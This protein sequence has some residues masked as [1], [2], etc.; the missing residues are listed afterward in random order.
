MNRLHI[1]LVC[2]SL[3]FSSLAQQTADSTQ[4]NTGVKDAP[5]IKSKKTKTRAIN[6]PHLY[7]GFSAG[8]GQFGLA[9][10]NQDMKLSNN[11][12]FTGGAFF[13]LRILKWL[14]A[15]IGCNY[16]MVSGSAKI[17]N[18]TASINAKDDEGDS[19]V[20]IIEAPNVKEEMEAELLEIPLSAKF[21]W[22]P[23]KWNL[24][25]KPG[26]AYSMALSSGYSQK[27]QVAISGHYPTE[28]ITFENLPQ[29]GY[30][31]MSHF[32][33]KGEL[34]IKNSI[35]PFIGAG[36]VFPAKTG[37][38]FIEGKYYPGTIDFSNGAGNGTLFEGTMDNQNIQD[39]NFESITEE[40]SK[41]GLGG[42]LV[43]IGLRF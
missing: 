26:I 35:N 11:L 41:V 31:L 1:V 4:I 37:N 12:S 13:E 38:F 30:F 40:A 18:Y 16:T 28:N 14:G 27:N 39:Y 21:I 24:Y 9:L 10:D 29:H 3:G 5:A 15:E 2:L 8:A 17:E 19:Y 33:N 23:G 22:S 7:W 36:V 43:Q 42:F 34:A 25:L 6:Y 20:H 32:K